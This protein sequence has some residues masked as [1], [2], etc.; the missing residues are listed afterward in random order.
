MEM[1]KKQIE[2][3]NGQQ[4]IRV[5]LPERSHISSTREDPI[6]NV[7]EST[8][9]DKRKK[10]VAEVL[11][12]ENT[13][14]RQA[15]EVPEQTARPNVFSLLGGKV[16]QGETRPKNWAEQ[17]LRKIIYSVIADKKTN[18]KTNTELAR[19][20]LGDNQSSYLHKESKTY[21]HQKSLDSR[22]LTFM[23][24]VQILSTMFTITSRLWHIG[25]MIGH[26][27]VECSRPV[28][29]TQL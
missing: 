19:K 4:P 17:D 28:W 15:Y 12:F 3:N 21:P 29:G 27:C 7:N 6:P 5:S 14:E 26:L 9:R 10:N 24:V 20:A 8:S 11:R 25:G 16:A 13:N 2:V 22:S 1:L 18:G 23:M